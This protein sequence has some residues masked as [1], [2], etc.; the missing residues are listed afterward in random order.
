MLRV[1]LPLALF[2]CFFYFCSCE[3]VTPSQAKAQ[4]EALARK[5]QE[6]TEELKKRLW[7][8]V[9]PF[10]EA[11]VKALFEIPADSKLP[12]SP[13]RVKNLSKKEFEEQYASKGIPVI[14]EDGMRDWK[15][16]GVWDCAWFKKEFPDEKVEGWQYKDNMS[17]RASEKV[18]TTFSKLNVTD[19]SYE[20][21]DESF[22][23]SKFDPK[24]PN[25]MR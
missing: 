7:K 11:K 25:V 18:E 16:N 10:D 14:V 15:G 21:G 13:K 8:A 1:L 19:T 17:L 22:T 5:E 20:I 12:V 9:L 2:S 3:K 23:A 4:I 6:K 24:N